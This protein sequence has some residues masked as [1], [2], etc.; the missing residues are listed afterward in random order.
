MKY[1]TR[2]SARAPPW[3]T[4]T[5]LL[6][7]RRRSAADNAWILLSLEDAEVAS[8]E[9]R[10]GV[11]PVCADLQSAASPLGHRA[12]DVTCACAQRMGRDSN[13]R[14]RYARTAA[15]A[16]RCLQPTQPPIQ[17]V[18]FRYCSAPGGTRTLTLLPATDLE[19]AAS[20]QFRHQ[21]LLLCAPEGQVHQEGV[22][23][24]RAKAH[25]LLRHACLPFHHQCKWSCGLPGSQCPPPDSN[26]E[27]LGPEPSASARLGQMGVCV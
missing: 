13:P 4:S 10:T 19:T 20:T 23:P 1:S 9:A 16:G 12:F 18:Y 25:M 27:H 21:R 5:A 24:S 26:R 11:E 8:P 15:L 6:I 3:C 22:E 14:A 2:R 7:I 17:G